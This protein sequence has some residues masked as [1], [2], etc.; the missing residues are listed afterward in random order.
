MFCFQSLPQVIRSS[1]NLY[2][3]HGVRAVEIVWGFLPMFAAL[4]HASLRGS[5]FGAGV[6]P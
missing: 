5:S 4:A 6:A 3:F 1:R 2:T